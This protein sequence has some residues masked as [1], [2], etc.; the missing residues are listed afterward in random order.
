[1]KFYDALQLDPAILKRKI[2]ACDEKKEKAY[3]WFAMSVRS[4]LIVA[5][6]IIFISLLSSVFGADQY[7]NGCCIVLYD[8]G[9]SFC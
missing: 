4:V 2:A 5:A 7:P 6:A 1:M 9:D 3:Y 8:F